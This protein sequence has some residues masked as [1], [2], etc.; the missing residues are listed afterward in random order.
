MNAI[1]IIAMLD[2]AHLRERGRHQWSAR[3]PAHEDRGPSLSVKETDDGRTLLH[4]FAGCSVEQITDSL[5][6][7]LEDLFPDTSGDRP[8]A[9]PI[10]RRGLL[11]PAQAF[12]LVA[13]EMMFAAVAAA[14][15]AH[16]L[17]LTEA[18]RARL[19]KAAGRVAYF[20]EQVRA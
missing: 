5:G 10:R 4:C 6:I 15:L 13:D 16:G 20:R 11:P 12:E 1:R 14:N 3:C 8:G 17:T 2:P 18:D 7:D 9:G 19:T